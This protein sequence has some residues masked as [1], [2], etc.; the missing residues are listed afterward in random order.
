MTLNASGPI[1]LAGATAGQSI[2]VE[3]GLSSTGTISLNQASV[4][5]LAGV[6]SGAITMPTNFYGKSNTVPFASQT[7]ATPG[8]YSFVVPAGVSKISVV[9][10]GH[11]G[12][13]GS[14]ACSCCLFRNKGGG[15]GGA[16][17][18][19]NCIPT[20]PGETLTVRVGGAI[21]C[22]YTYAFVPSC[23]KRSS[24]VLIS[25]VYGPSS[26]TNGACTGNLT[27]PG[28]AAASGVGAVKFSGGNG[29]RGGGGAAGYAGNGGAGAP[30]N[31]TSGAAGS[32][33][34]GGGGAGGGSGNGGGGGGGVGLVVQGPN[35][36]G[37]V[38]SPSLRNGGGGGSSGTNGG[39]ATS[40]GGPY[41][42]GE[43]GTA[44]GAGGG[45]Y[46]R[47]GCAAGRMGAGG[48][49]IIWGGTGKSYPNN[50]A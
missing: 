34:G 15:G 46:C 42:G 22:N 14:T 24:T 9:T 3:L 21:G 1:S 45:D 31:N 43:G 38:G 41:Q 30:M 23:V 18:Y 50:S 28:G 40:L 37:G 2:A 47:C 7:Y 20:T 13:G 19:T 49:R 32:G 17:S 8:I 25:A 10:V 33:G 29:V 36:A 5:T 16:L 26:I 44:G 27:T 11:G 39:A 6:P 48:V 12:T 4:R 35:G